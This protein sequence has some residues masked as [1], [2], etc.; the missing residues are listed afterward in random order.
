LIEDDEDAPAGIVGAEFFGGSKQKQEF[1]DPEAEAHAADSI[2][3]LESSFDR[4]DSAA[5]SSE[6]ARR[7]GR[8]LTAHLQSTLYGSEKPFSTLY[9][10]DV[11]WSTPL[12]V[13][14][15]RAL[16]TPLEALGSATSFYRKVDVAVTGCRQVSSSQFEVHWELGLTWPIFW[17]PRVLLCMRSDV[18]V[19]EQYQIVSQ[20]DELLGGKDLLGA[21][22]GQLL[23]RFWDVYHIGMTPSAEASPRYPVPTKGISLPPS[24]S[25]R[26]LP[27][28]WY[29]QPSLLDTGAR[30]DSNAAVLPNHGF[31]TA[32]KTMGP[33]KDDY[34]PTSPIEVQLVPVSSTQLR[35]QWSVPVAVETLACNQLLPLPSIGDDVNADGDGDDDDRDAAASA[36]ELQQPRCEYAWVGP[37]RVATVPYGGGPQ[38]PGISAARRRLYEQVVKDGWTPKLDGAAAKRPVF[39]FWQGSAKA[40]YT[41]QGLGMAVYEA[42]PGF[43]APNYVGIELEL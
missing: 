8:E 10:T 13:E 7:L 34:V 36:A 43:V 17:E 21:V 12:Q 1:Y 29:W 5:F 20:Q 39:F 28:R 9:G 32:I 22:A 15:K 23:P 11:R 30:E 14:A 16:K 31:V 38:D 3:V 42:R 19:N 37:R 40:C 25:V 24:Y 33:Q 26:D 35:L 2:R 6:A 4:F 41:R 27:P 18:S